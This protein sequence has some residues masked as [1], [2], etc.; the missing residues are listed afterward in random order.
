[1]YPAEADQA[2]EAPC[3]SGYGIGSCLCPTNIISCME[4]HDR[5]IAT[6]VVEEVLPTSPVVLKPASFTEYQISEIY[7]C[8]AWFVHQEQVCKTLNLRLRILLLHSFID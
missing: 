7:T 5:M 8:L 1:M 4:M 3:L 2:R 6:W